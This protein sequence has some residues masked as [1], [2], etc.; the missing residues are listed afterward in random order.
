LWLWEGATGGIY[1]QL[2]TWVPHVRNMRGFVAAA[3]EVESPRMPVQQQ[4]QS[5][6]CS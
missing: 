3:G 1:G 6:A 2:V 4:Q 5:L